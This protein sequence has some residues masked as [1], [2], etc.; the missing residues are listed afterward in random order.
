MRTLLLG[1][2]L[3]LWMLAGCDG[4]GT[5]AGDDDGG[6]PAIDGSTGVDGG[7]SI[8]GGG[9]VY[10]EPVC[11][12]PLASITDLSAAYVNTAAGVRA[13]TL[14]I[15]D[16]RYPM[17]RLFIEGQTDVELARW[18]QT[19]TT[20]AG[21]LDGF[22][23]AVHEG[24]HIW[25]IRMIASGK[26]PYRVRDDLVIRASNL[27]NF[28]RS[29]IL[30]VHVDVADDFYASTYLMGQ[31][32]TQGFNNL[33]DEYNAYTHSLASR[34]CTRDSLGAGTRIT[35]RDGILTMMYY[36]E[37]YLKLARTRHPADY[38]AIK[39]DPES[40]RLILTI[41]DRAEFWL[42]LSARFPS[43]GL[44]DTMI[45]GWVYTPDNKMEIDLLR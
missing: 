39:G 41:W 22:D 16:R 44:K 15:A 9:A 32:G 10:T 24:Q 23:T 29:E 8:D 18:F 25:D 27:T 37:L 7:A 34:Y 20:F 26:W 35:A 11:A 17:G 2:A 6:G 21:V 31:S 36:V 33:L 3:S 28:A 30:T 13:A 43:L 14:G 38:A 19:T 4:S 45:R 40:V 42:A 5:A 1:I 12:D